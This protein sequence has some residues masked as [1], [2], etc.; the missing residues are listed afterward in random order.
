MSKHYQ[1][2]I[3]ILGSGA[4]GLSVALRLDSHLKIAVVAKGELSE[5]SSR[6][7]QG[8]ISAVLDPEDTIE[9]HVQDTVNAG[10]GLCN[11]QAVEYMAQHSADQIHWLS[12]L[13]MP[14][15]HNGDDPAALHLTREGGHSK[16]RIVHAADATGKA[17]STSMIDAA[18]Q[19]DNI[20]FFERHIAVDLI[21]ATKLEREPQRVLGAYIFNRDTGHIEV[22]HAR[23]VVLATGGAS[24]V[25]L[26]S[27]IHI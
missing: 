12:E 4:A 2:D 23:C 16:R 22:F 27:L 6:Y 26:L 18:R 5:G 8:G 11:Q 1:H 19:Q 20:E 25:Y 24:K 9:S 21:T 13:G 15:T 14:F 10:A 17:L 7:A 3:L